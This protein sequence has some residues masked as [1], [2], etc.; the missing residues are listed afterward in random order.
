MIHLNMSPNPIPSARYIQSR[1]EK[2]SIFVTRENAQERLANVTNP[3][4]KLVIA[5]ILRTPGLPDFL[6]RRFI[7]DP[8]AA[9][10]YDVIGQGGNA[11][12]VRDG[13]RRVRKLYLETEFLTDEEKVAKMKQWEERQRIT[14]HHMGPYVVEQSFSI[15]DNPLR[16]EGQSSIVTASQRL[17]IPDHA[18]SM[19]EIASGPGLRAFA[20]AGRAM[21]RKT[22]PA[23]VPDVVGDG[24][25]LIE[26]NSR[27]IRLVDTISLSESDL[28]EQGVYSRALV[29]LGITT[30][31]S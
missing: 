12:V 10:G 9:S 2:L 28:T 11:V 16:Q 26:A 23:M 5:S 31:E 18:V 17:V 15:D 6:Y 21:H 4:R 13:N 8:L 30:P 20:D 22:F 27:S 25:V 7:S 19:A 29:T 1:A 24:N 14:L 3:A